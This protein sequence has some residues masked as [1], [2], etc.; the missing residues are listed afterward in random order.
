MK[1][2]YN[3]DTDINTIRLSTHE[4]QVIQDFFQKHYDSY[5]QSEMLLEETANCN[6]EEILTHTYSVLTLARI[7]GQFEQHK[8][9]GT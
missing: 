7:A 4:L 5:W 1:I 9:L 3:K 2:E 8:R 6:N